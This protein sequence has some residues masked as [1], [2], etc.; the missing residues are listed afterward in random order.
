MS[1]FEALTSLLYR[2][3]NRDAYKGERHPWDLGPPHRRATKRSAASGIGRVLRD[4]AGGVSS[5]TY[6]GRCRSLNQ[7]R[8]WGSEPLTRPLRRR[9]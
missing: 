1:L 8:T 3:A 6:Q 2:G 4:L 9:L 5:P 7:S